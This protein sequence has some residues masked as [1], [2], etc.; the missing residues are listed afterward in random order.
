MLSSG[1]VLG[2]L[3]SKPLS[4]AKRETHLRTAEAVQH[5][6]VSM[7]LV[8]QLAHG[9]LPHKI[10]ATSTRNVIVVPTTIPTALGSSTPGGWSTISP[11]VVMV[12][13]K[14]FDAGHRRGSGDSEGQGA[15]FTVDR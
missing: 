11:V 15:M 10:K 3:R 5:P 2:A 12:K 14:R 1:R 9:R 4:K 8:P 7:L 6:C 13:E